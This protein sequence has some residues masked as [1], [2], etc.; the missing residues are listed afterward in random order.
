MKIGQFT[1][2]DWPVNFFAQ[3]RIIE[4]AL[5]L[6]R[7]EPKRRFSGETTY[8]IEKKSLPGL[9]IFRLRERL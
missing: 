8:G 3:F 5:A 2:H 1:G 9:S 7:Q 6:A 4:K